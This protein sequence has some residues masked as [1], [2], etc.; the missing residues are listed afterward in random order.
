MSLRRS[1]LRA[2]VGRIRRRIEGA[3]PADVR[4][5]LDSYRTTC[6]IVASIQLGLIHAMAD[7]D[8][9]VEELAGRLG[10]DVDALRRFLRGLQVL[11]VVERRHDRYA[12]T[13]VGRSILS[14]HSIARDLALLIT[15]EYL[16]A[17]LNIRTSVLTGKP[18]F[19]S[20]FGQSVW[21]HRQASPEIDAAFNRFMISLARW[22]LDAILDVVDFKGRPVLVDVG[23][24]H[25]E[26]LARI[27][28]NNPGLRGIA[29]DQPHV[30]EAAGPLFEKLGVRDRCDFMAGS[31]LEEVPVGGDIYILQRILHDW[32]DETCLTILRNCRRA[33][34]NDGRLVISEN[35]VEEE[36]LDP[37]LVMRDLH[38]MVVPGG[39]E[40]TRGEFE[41]LL[42]EAGFALTRC[43]PR[44]GTYILEAR[45]V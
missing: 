33:M 27:L 29:F 31:F 25:G 28:Q 20:V 44:P 7:G 34:H 23:C 40:R 3:P 26:V 18:A 42:K 30:I 35:A 41:Q 10:A 9:T 8:R 1:P 36:E 13:T 6:I 16:P 43:E 2:L 32:D 39:R 17:W 14:D 24:G 21:H 45:P 11:G 4:R 37:G 5:L 15:E 38:M 22:N 19:D 12:L